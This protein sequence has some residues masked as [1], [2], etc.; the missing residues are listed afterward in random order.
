MAVGGGAGAGGGG[1][2]AEVPWRCGAGALV[3]G[4]K[5]VVTAVQQVGW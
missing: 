1:G 2:V 4:G 3:G 5:L